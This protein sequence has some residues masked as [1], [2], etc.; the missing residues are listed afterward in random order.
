MCVDVFFNHTS[1][2]GRCRA[3]LRVLNALTAVLDSFLTDI[4]MC[5]A[6]CLLWPFTYAQ[7]SPT[8][9]AHT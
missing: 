3:F 4:L 6:L 8:S 1:G 9:Y 2:R 7:D 5:F